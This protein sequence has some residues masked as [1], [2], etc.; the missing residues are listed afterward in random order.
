MKIE[1]VGFVGLGLIGGSIA[2]AIKAFHPEI[3]IMA[4]MRTADTLIEAA[5]EGTVDIACTA[6]D[7]QFAACDCIFLRSEERRVGKECRSRGSPYH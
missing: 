6:V 7:G 3:Q 1:T 4:Y 5:N 2:K